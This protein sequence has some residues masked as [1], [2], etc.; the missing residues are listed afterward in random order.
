MFYTLSPIVIIVVFNAII[1][2]VLGSYL[3]GNYCLLLSFACVCEIPVW[4][5]W[6]DCALTFHLSFI[7]WLNLTLL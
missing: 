7:H 3:Y 2:L 6:F 1:Q 4:T 5:S